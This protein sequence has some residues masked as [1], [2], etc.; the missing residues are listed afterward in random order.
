MQ[1]ESHLK[2]QP[3]DKEKGRQESG[4]SRSGANLD[5]DDIIRMAEDAGF[6]WETDHP[7]IVALAELAYAAGAAAEREAC[8]ELCVKL[9]VGGGVAA[10]CAAAIRARGEK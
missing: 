2:A 10:D 9:A 8:A 5:R 6:I 1:S 7:A 3:S 4:Q